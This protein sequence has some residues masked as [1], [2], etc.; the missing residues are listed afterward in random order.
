MA[1]LHQCQG[2]RL[3]LNRRVDDGY[4][5]IQLT[6]GK[7]VHRQLRGNHQP[8]IFQSGGGSLVRGIRGFKAAPDAAKNVRF[9]RQVKRNQKIIGQEGTGEPNASRGRPARRMFASVA[10]K[11]L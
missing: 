2:F 4:F 5:S 11:C 9:P 1:I 7:V 3:G 10:R 8:D 6:Q